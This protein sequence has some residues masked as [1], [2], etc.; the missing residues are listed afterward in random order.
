MLSWE[1]NFSEQKRREFHF[2]RL[3]LFLILFLREVQLPLAIAAFLSGLAT[4]LELAFRQFHLSSQLTLL[5]TLAIAALLFA[6]LRAYRRL[7]SLQELVVLYD[8]CTQAEG[9]ACAGTEIDLGSWR[10]EL[11]GNGRKIRFRLKYSRNTGTLLFTAIFC[12]AILLSAPALLAAFAEKVNYTF[13]LAEDFKNLEETIETLDEEDFLE[14]EEKDFLQNAL[15]EL[16]ENASGNNPASTLEE[17]AALEQSLNQR[18]QEAFQQL[19]EA[20]ASQALLEELLQQLGENQF[21]FSTEQLSEM[22]AELEK[23]FQKA[24]EDNPAWKKRTDSTG[25]D[26]A[27]QLSQC[28]RELNA[29]LAKLKQCKRGKPMAGNNSRQ[30]ALQKLQESLKATESSE[31]Q[32]KALRLLLDQLQGTPRKNAQE[33][34]DMPGPENDVDQAALQASEGMQNV[35]SASRGRS[36]AELAGTNNTDLKTDDTAPEMLLT[37][38]EIDLEKSLLMNLSYTAPSPPQELVEV[39]EGALS[40][41]P[42]GSRERRTDIVLPRH[43]S[44]VA[45]YFNKQQQPATP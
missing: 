29:S 24:S 14:E 22:M 8:A 28:S 40:A 12:A 31:K 45:N 23:L 1:K 7:P 30:K 20:A 42:A 35:Y 2:L 3:R 34:G 15:E 32:K 39:S 21:N 16:Q 37:P 18:L 36:D 17:L 43:R 27:S 11:P 4:L 38:Q 44:T 5:L 10:T 41:T 9:F 25:L 13:D 6:V 33:V 19:N 26:W